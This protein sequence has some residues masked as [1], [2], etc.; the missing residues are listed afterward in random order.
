M[1]REDLHTPVSDADAPVARATGSIPYSQRRRY[2]GGTTVSFLRLWLG[3]VVDRSVRS[4]R[5]IATSSCS[6]PLIGRILESRDAPFDAL[7]PLDDQIDHVFERSSSFPD[8]FVASQQ[9]QPVPR[10]WTFSPSNAVDD[11]RLAPQTNAD[12]DQRVRPIVTRLAVSKL[13]EFWW[14][15]TDSFAEPPLRF[16]AMSEPVADGLADSFRLGCVHRSEP[17][18]LD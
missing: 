2:E 1:T 10:R 3:P 13:S 12:L 16:R 5:W 6:R 14:R 9:A 7:D 8:A 11:V 17:P 4:S 15:H 18:G